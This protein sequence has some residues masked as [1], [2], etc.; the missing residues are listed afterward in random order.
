MT[1]S[2][3]APVFTE[4]YWNFT[5]AEGDKNPEGKFFGIKEHG[6][7]RCQSSK[8]GNKCSKSS[9]MWA[10]KNKIIIITIISCQTDQH[11]DIPYLITTPLHLQY[12]TPCFVTSQGPSSSSQEFALAWIASAE[13]S[14]MMKMNECKMWLRKYL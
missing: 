13:W 3:V 14:L 7:K 11:P 1:K 6:G 12:S 8:T 4:T 10:G 5:S 9:E 2:I